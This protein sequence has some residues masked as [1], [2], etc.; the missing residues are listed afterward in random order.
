MWRHTFAEKSASGDL[1][2]LPLRSSPFGFFRRLR[3]SPTGASYAERGTGTKKVVHL[4]SER[5]FA[6]KLDWDDPVCLRAATAWL[7]E[8]VGEAQRRG[9]REVLRKNQKRRIEE[10]GNRRKKARRRVRESEHAER[11]S[12]VISHPLSASACRAGDSG[13]QMRARRRWGLR[14]MLREKRRREEADE[15]EMAA[16]EFRKCRKK[17]PRLRALLRR[18][19]SAKREIGPVAETRATPGS[20]GSLLA[21]EIVKR[22]NADGVCERK[23]RKRRSLPRKSVQNTRRD[24]ACTGAQ[25][26][27]KPTGE[28]P[29]K[30]LTKKNATVVSAQA[31]PC[32]LA[33]PRVYRH[34][35]NQSRN[36]FGILSFAEEAEVARRESRHTLLRSSGDVH[37]VESSLLSA[38]AG[39]EKLFSEKQTR[40]VALRQVPSLWLALFSA[41]P[42]KSLV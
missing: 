39:K 15:A 34:L 21:T 38:E 7:A 9:L 42:P 25:F 33:L 12:V 22:G 29:V 31:M 3:R 4:V 13:L 17:D 30:N 6:K 41:G 26:A 2:W 16:R 32:T 1:G 10:A 18:G 11:P 28:K 23:V 8:R 27:D 5:L 19:I 36:D 40:Q 24:S 20:A 35:G 14:M 37:T